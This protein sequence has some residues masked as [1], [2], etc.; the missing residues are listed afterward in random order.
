MCQAVI[1]YGDEREAKGEAKRL[2]QIISN[3]MASTK[4]T[5]ENALFLTGTTME[6]YEGSLALLASLERSAN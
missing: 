6:D 3:V 4:F 2:V 5:L 1:E